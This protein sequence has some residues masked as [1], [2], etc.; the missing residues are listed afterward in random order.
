MSKLR[1]RQVPLELARELDAL[2]EAG[3][4]QPAPTRELSTA[5]NNILGFQV[6]RVLD[7]KA[8]AVRRK[9]K[10]RGR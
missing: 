1:H 5:V 9:R 8:S 2:L 3:L 10:S 7:L 4:N 6:A